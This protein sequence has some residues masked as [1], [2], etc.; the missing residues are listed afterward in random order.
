LKVT[1][2]ATSFSAAAGDENFK[3]IL[4]DLEKSI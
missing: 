2:P 3:V 4:T 1:D